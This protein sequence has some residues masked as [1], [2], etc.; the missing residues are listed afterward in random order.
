MSGALSR[1]KLARAAH[2]LNAGQLVLLTDDLRLPDPV[3]AVRA[4]PPDSL[5]IVRARDKA[6]R[7]ELAARLRGLAWARGLILLVADDP[8][9]ARA[10]GA[11]GLHLP[12]IRARQAA[13]WRA[14][15]PG[16]LITAAAHSLG[17][18]LKASHADAV[19][20]SPIFATASHKGAPALS[21]ARARLIARGVATP[22]FALG[23][24]SASNAALLSGFSGIAAISALSP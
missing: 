16:W 15:N 6:R 3:A 11:N 20:L 14:K 24:V 23:G 4:L 8:A 22:V 19:L 5:V 7:A 1:A 2:S 18:V 9:L 21:A 10:I 13:H 12:E 17:A